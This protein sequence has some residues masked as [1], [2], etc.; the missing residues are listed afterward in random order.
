MTPTP[1]GAYQDGQIIDIHKITYDI[2]KALEQHRIK[3]KK[4]VFSLQ[5][6]NVIT[7]EVDLPSVAEEQLASMLEYEIQQFFPTSLE[8]YVIQYK[9][10]KTFNED[11]RKTRLLVAAIPKSIVQSYWELSKELNLKPLALDIHSNS[12][13][14]LFMKGLKL[15][16]LDYREHTLAV[17]D[18]GYEGININIIKDGTL[19]FSRLLPIGGKEIDIM[20]SKVFEIP[21]E[22]AE[23]LK[24]TPKRDILEEARFDNLVNSCIQGWGEEIQRIFKYHTS[25]ELG[26]RIDQIYLMGGHANL[27]KIPEGMKGYFNIPTNVLSYLSNIKLNVSK[28][29]EEIDLKYYLN[30]I[31]AIIR[32]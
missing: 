14:K 24:K 20:I 27:K 29:N 11:D 6:T 1:E 12:I 25:R 10:L 5:S 31:G 17:V 16:G 7:R 9:K 26:N 8:D 30:A 22:Q 15:D 2:D 13:S 3:A 21:K 18:L 19:E 28:G 23:E 32:K 4:V